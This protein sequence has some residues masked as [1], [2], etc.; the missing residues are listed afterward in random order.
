MRPRW[1]VGFRKAFLAYSSAIRI[2]LSDFAFVTPAMT[3]V[4]I[5]SSRRETVLAR[6]SSS[7]MPSWQAHQ[8]QDWNSRSR[9]FRSHEGRAGDQASRRR[10]LLADPRGGGPLPAPIR[11]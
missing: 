5:S 1:L 7:G 2:R 3:A 10:E 8:P 9:T 6:E 4:V 11:G